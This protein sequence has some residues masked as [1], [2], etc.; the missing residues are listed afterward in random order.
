MKMLKVTLCLWQLIL[1][2]SCSALAATK[3]TT[4]LISELKQTIKT[5]KYRWDTSIL[6]EQGWETRGH[7]VQGFPLLTYTCGDRKSN[8]V[9]L[10]LSAVHGDE[11]G[12][13]YFG[14]RMVEWLKANPQLCEKKFIVV[15]PFVNPDGFF[16]YTWGTRTNY[17]KVDLNRNFNTPDWI[18]KALS[19]WKSKM[20]SQR[21]Y[22]PGDKPASEPETLFQQTL[23]D[24]YKP[25]KILSIHAPLNILDYDG[26][27][28]AEN[29][30]FSK[31]YIDSCES[32]KQA[33]SKATPLLKFFAYGVFPG[34]L[35]NYAGKMRGIP[36]F[37]VELPTAKS[38]DAAFYFGDLEKGTRLFLDYE[39]TKRLPVGTTL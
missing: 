27:I 16:R 38:E 32:L 35:G 30:E 39:V 28:N 25:T 13:V 7:S 12:P 24:E 15:A 2:F 34:S 20:N 31:T 33:V 21:R 22:Y 17:N 23:I 14:F 26:P 6:T 19:L 29:T 10:I 8:N 37:T 36:T 3:T 1:C 4:D 18:E 5:R 9:S 11:V